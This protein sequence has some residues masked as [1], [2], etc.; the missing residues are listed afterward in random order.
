MKHFKKKFKFIGR[1]VDWIDLTDRIQNDNE[2]YDIININYKNKEIDLIYNINI[3]RYL[4]KYLC[5]KLKK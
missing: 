1:D 5:D 4:P 2:L 3:C